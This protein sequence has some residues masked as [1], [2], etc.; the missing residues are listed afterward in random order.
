[1]P[2]NDATKQASAPGYTVPGH[3]A[4]ALSTDRPEMLNLYIAELKRDGTDA[5]ALLETQIGIAELV[6]D[7][8]CERQALYQQLGERTETIDYILDLLPDLQ[9]SVDVL[10]RIRKERAG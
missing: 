5:V 3:F 6:R 4:I 7:L 8:L 2:D 1:M 10:T 9:R